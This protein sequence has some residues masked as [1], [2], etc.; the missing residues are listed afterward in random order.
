[1][2]EN[3]GRDILTLPITAKAALT[4]NTFCAPEAV[5]GTSDVGTSGDAVG[6]VVRDTIAA[7]K[8][9]DKIVMGTAWVTTSANLASGDPVACDTG[10]TARKATTAD[11]VVGTAIRN[12]N[13]G[14]LAEIGLSIFSAGIF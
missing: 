12:T 2:T 5:D 14:D 7:G 3:I 11:I 13:S 10:G 8:V 9:G 6:G 4:G 1:M